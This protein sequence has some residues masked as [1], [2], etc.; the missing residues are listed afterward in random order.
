MLG[1]SAA[2]RQHYGLAYFMHLEAIV[3]DNEPKR[4]RHREVI[5]GAGFIFTAFLIS[6]F[7]GSF[8]FHSS[9]ARESSAP[10]WQSVA[11]LVVFIM[12]MT[13]LV[14]VGKIYLRNPRVAVFLSLV[15]L[16]MAVTA[17]ELPGIWPNPS[18]SL[19]VVLALVGWQTMWI[20]H[21]DNP[22]KYFLDFR[23]WTFVLLAL[24]L[25]ISGGSYC[26]SHLFGV[27][28]LF[29]CP[30]EDLL[31][32]AQGILVLVVVSELFLILLEILYNAV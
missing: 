26:R 32:A 12:G 20:K 29:P 9:P 31:L 24:W 15:A 2:G 4:R 13:V 7:L 17:L 21:E 1:R 25:Y 3:K 16:A 6:A 30:T 27:S 10:A 28:M 14:V 23:N 8:L 22:A 11:A 18:G 5:L 19:A